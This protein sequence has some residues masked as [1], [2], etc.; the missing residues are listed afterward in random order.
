MARGWR[1]ETGGWLT[2]LLGLLLGLSPGPLMAQQVDPQPAA[3][4]RLDLDSVSLLDQ[5][6]FDLLVLTEKWEQQVFKILPGEGESVAGA[7]AGGESFLEVTLVR[8]PDR[9]YRIARGDVAQRVS[10]EQLLERRTRRLLEEEDYPQAIEHLTFLQTHY[11]ATPGLAALIRECGEASV[12]QLRERG[13]HAHALAI[14]EDLQ[15]RERSGSDRYLAAIDREVDILV[16]SYLNTDALATAQR[17]VARLE[18]DYGAESLAS[19]ERWNRHFASLAERLLEQSAAAEEEGDLRQALL[20][21]IRSQAVWPRLEQASTAVKRLRDAYP[22]LRIGV[23][24][25]AVSADAAS[26]FD[27]PARRIGLAVAPG[28]MEF[29]GVGGEGGSYRFQLGSH[30][31]AEDR[32]RLSLRLDRSAFPDHEAGQPASHLLAAWLHALSQPEQAEFDPIWRSVVQRVE[33]TGVDQLQV[34]LR[35]PHVLPH[36]LMHWP[37]ASDSSPLAPPPLYRW[38]PDE[39]SRDSSLLWAGWLAPEPGQP[40]EVLEVFQP[41]AA[42]AV[43]DLLRGELDL[44][45]RLF[46]A[47]AERLRGMP[48]V[49]VVQYALPSIHLMV[50]ISDHP[51]LDQVEFRRGLMYG[52]DRQSVLRDELL[53]GMNDPDSQVISGPFPAQRDVNDPLA[54]AYN[55]QVAAY[56]HDPRLAQLLIQLAINRWRAAL[57]ESEADRPIPPIRLAV[58]SHSIGQQVGQAWV[59]QIERYGVECQLV[60]LEGRDSQNESAEFDLR[61]IEVRMW[62]PAVDVQ[63]LLGPGGLAASRDPYIVMALE[64]LQQ[65]ANWPDVRAALQRLHQLVHYQL[66]VLP[67]WQLSDW[68]AYRRPLTGVVARPYHVY[69]DLEQWRLVSP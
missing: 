69:Q 19:V 37:V 32:S 24:Q 29:A 22:L 49:E 27:W 57:P 64:S 38:Q 15:R 36:A 31:L 13:E 25:P 18:S 62:E 20:L 41:Q 14:L 6:P 52:F 66:P 42:M 53:G 56:G 60:I 50:P 43:S 34:V 33:V 63:R 35:R 65:A 30:R 17:L 44:I 54:Y 67:L 51:L 61:L 48:D 5:A 8:F 28:L 11:P 16:D 46:P 55:R 40:V 3:D 59:D 4:D 68:L 23:L 26:L 2:G 10:F 9:R 12:R 21:A 45:D 1:L 7:E 47:D 58:P 39:S